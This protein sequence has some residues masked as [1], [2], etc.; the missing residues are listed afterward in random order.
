M[1][2][3]CG[4]DGCANTVGDVRVDGE[5]VRAL[6]YHRFGDRIVP[7]T[8]KR[9][10]AEL[11]LPPGW[12]VP[13]LAEREDRRIE[14][15]DGETLRYLEGARRV[16]KRYRARDVLIPLDVFSY[17]VCPDHGMLDVPDPDA[18]VAELRRFVADTAPARRRRWRVFGAAMS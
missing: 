17:I 15:I 12:I 9:N 5:M 4:V 10:D 3:V 14:Q 6:I 1:L 18:A 16:A 13:E 7:F 2:L 11:G 8:P